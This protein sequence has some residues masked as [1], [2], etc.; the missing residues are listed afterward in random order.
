MYIVIEI[1]NTG[2]TVGTFVFS[3]GSRNEAEAKYHALLS[4]AAVSSV[5]IHGVTLLSGSGAEI[6]HESYAHSA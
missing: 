2:E 4:V 1:Q 3:F 5:P 6:K